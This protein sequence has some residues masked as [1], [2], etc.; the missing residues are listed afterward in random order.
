MEEP[1][2]SGESK[3]PE[4][5]PVIS[6]EDRLTAENLH[7]KLMNLSLH[8]QRIVNELTD[9]RA[10]RS[11]LQAQLIDTR[12]HLGEKYNVDFG[13]FDIRAEDGAIVPKDST[14]PGLIR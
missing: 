14:L 1:K 6:V 9:V 10:Q 7:L 11:V 5:P 4:G 2:D 12:R 13:K 8:E 3:E